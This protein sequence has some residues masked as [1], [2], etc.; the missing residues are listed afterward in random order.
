[1]Q[2]V[3]EISTDEFQNETRF[4]AQLAAIIIGLCEKRQDIA[5]LRPEAYR[6][7]QDTHNNV[8]CKFPRLIV[9][10]IERYSRVLNSVT[11]VIE[12][13]EKTFTGSGLIFKALHCVCGDSIDDMK[14]YDYQQQG[15]DD[16]RKLRACLGHFI[17]T[18]LS[19]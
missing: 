19:K 11:V 13:T 6:K 10:E 2:Q 15:T 1:M 16:G 14:L 17:E 8:N 7:F 18:V 9:Y 5:L 12:R 3:V 4:S